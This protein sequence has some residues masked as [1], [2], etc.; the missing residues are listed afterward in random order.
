M[1]RSGYF[2]CIKDFKLPAVIY[3][4]PESPY[5]AALLHPNNNEGEIMMKFHGL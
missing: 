3:C 2:C 5:L 1:P 4:V